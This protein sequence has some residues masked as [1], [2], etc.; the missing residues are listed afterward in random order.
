MALISSI[1]NRS[2]ILIVFIGIGLASFIMMDMFGSSTSAFGNRP[3]NT[4]GVIN[5]QEIDYN[6]VKRTEEVFYRGATGSTYGLKD[7]IWNYYLEKSILEEE[8]SELGL[9]VGKAE[10]NDLMFGENLSPVV[11]QVFI[12]RQTGQVDRA[13]LMDI[14]NKMATDRSQLNTSYMEELVGQVQKNRLQE[15]F[16]AM[17]TQGLY[18][19]N[20]MA[21]FFATENNTS[22]DFNYVKVPFSDVEDSAVSVTDADYNTF[23]SDNKAKYYTEEETRKI[24][25]VVFDV[26]PSAA[27]S[28]NYYNQLN[29]KIAAFKGSKNDS[30]YVLSN[31]GNM[32]TTYTKKSALS[33]EIQS[34]MLSLP[35]GSVVGPYLEGTSYK[36]AKVSDRKMIPDSVRAQHI[37]IRANPSDANSFAAAF[38]RIDSLKTALDNGSKFDNLAAQVS[39]DPN[40]A[41]QGGDLGYFSERTS[42]MP[43]QF[44]NL[45]F[46]SAKEGSVNTVL[47]QMGVH[48]VK[49]N[50]KKFNGNEESVKVAYLTRSIIPSDATQKE[51][52]ETVK[53]FV[54]NNTDA[55]ALNTLVANDSNLSIETTTS[56]K[57]NDYIIPA[58]G[59]DPSS[60][61]LIRWSF[62]DGTDVN[63]LSPDFYV[64]RYSNP[65]T[66]ENYD[67]K[68]VVAALHSIQPAGMPSLENIKSEIAP[69]VLNQKKASFIA[70]S[71]AG[72]NIEGVA[73]QY[74]TSVE[75]LEGISASA[76]SVGVLG[77][78]P[79]VIAALMNL[80]PNESSAPIQGENGVYIVQLLQKNTV[81]A[82]VDLANTKRIQSTKLKTIARTELMKSL[83]ESAEVT[84]NRFKIY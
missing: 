68:F 52:R 27:D 16:T 54:N 6:K 18:T 55:E 25:Y 84:D 14:K 58:L 20:W 83:K 82:G 5:G 42:R 46:Y 21:E 48:L 67:S 22:L 31:G 56:L 13:N 79:K 30:T 80:S 50:D 9:N 17:V 43:P 81:G 66:Y 24:S 1:R 41:D 61:E 72:K 70:S 28:T 40:N 19:P 44:N 74:G 4:L 57:R 77:N 2:W 47:T 69:L 78:E 62:K 29:N 65:V 51:I 10:T 38:A 8:G 35:I 39:Q 49:L 11:Q 71:I 32:A 3:T 73:N 59:Q 34:D 7:M 15:K 12:D 75:N 37:L 63:N 33:P 36:L 26:S 76:T 53:E 60:R 45:V 23:L 64:Y